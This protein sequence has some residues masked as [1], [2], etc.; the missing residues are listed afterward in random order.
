MTIAEMH[1]LA[2]LLIDKADAEWFNPIE[3]D[4][5]I[6]LAIN[7]YTKTKYAVFETNEK[8]R[9]DLLTLVS[10]PYVVLADNTINLE[11]VPNFLFAL[12]VEVDID[13]DCGFKRGIPV[14]PMQQDDFSESQRDPFNRATDSYPQYLQFVET[15]NRIIRV[16]SDNTPDEI[17]LTYLNQPTAVDFGT[18]TDSNLPAHTH[19]EI[20][21][22]AVR[23][24]LATIESFEDYQVQLN[25]IN[26]QE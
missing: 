16:Y 7:E 26:N 2:D 21:N 12:R 23:K 22:L 5:F 3:K 1:I 13:S 17:R 8:V 9:E 15:G 18:G 25:E 4:R 24:M 20:V 19:E 10:S 11:V 14:T 6:N